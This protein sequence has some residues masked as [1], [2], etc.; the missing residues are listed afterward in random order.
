MR[1]CLQVDAANASGSTPLLQ[2]AAGAQAQWVNQGADLPAVAAALLAAGADA[3]ARDAF[4]QTA[5]HLAASA[6]DTALLKVLLDAG[7]APQSWWALAGSTA[8]ELVNDRWRRC[9]AP[10]IAD[11]GRHL[12]C[13][14]LALACQHVRACL[15]SP[16]AACWAAWPGLHTVPSIGT[17]S[18]MWLLHPVHTSCTHT[19]V[20]LSLL[21]PQLHHRCHSACLA[22]CQRSAAQRSTAQR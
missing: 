11:C 2:A 21:L 8:A 15:G 22:S 5:L 17:S 10:H 3:G 20:G 9:L 18:C 12:G 16:S 6:G 19:I 7:E 14:W 13:P 4:G 1:R